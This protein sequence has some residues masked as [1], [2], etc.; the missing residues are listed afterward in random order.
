MNERVTLVTT[1]LVLAI[2]MA[3]ALPGLAAR[4]HYTGVTVGLGGFTCK[5]DAAALQRDLAKQPGVKAVKATFSPARVTARLDEQ[6]MPVGRFVGLIAGHP[7]IGHPDQTYRANLVIHVDSEMCQGRKTMCPAC[8]PEIAKRLKDIKGVTTVTFDETGREV[9]IGFAKGATVT[10]TQ[11]KQAL[12][13]S[14]LDF[15]VQF[16]QAP[17]VPAPIYF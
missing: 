11:I 10:T 16:V 9:T 4:T 2:L 17:E 8:E 14:S 6:R 5:A 12:I 3:M 15:K 1:L 7:R 13:A